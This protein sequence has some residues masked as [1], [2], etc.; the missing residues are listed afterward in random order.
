LALPRWARVE[1]STSGVDGKKC[2]RCGR[3]LTTGVGGT[4]ASF[5][6]HARERD[7]LKRTCK[8]CM[9]RYQVENA[10]VM[11]RAR[12]KYDLIHGRR[13]QI[14]NTGADRKG[15]EAFLSGRDRQEDVDAAKRMEAFL[16]GIDVYD[17]PEG[18]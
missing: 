11:R 18:D 1:E 5:H 12:N 3:W 13:P 6:R 14:C 10:H 16:G 17:K 7:G 4:W 2:D 9:G 8:E 15:V